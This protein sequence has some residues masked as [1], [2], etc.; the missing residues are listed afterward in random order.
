MGG[1]GGGG[2]GGGD[3]QHFMLLLFQN[4]LLAPGLCTC[5]ECTTTS[6][7]SSVGYG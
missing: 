7:W 4:N 1:G 2:G 6:P 3:G 5:S